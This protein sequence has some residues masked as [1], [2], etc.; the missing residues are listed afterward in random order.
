[1]IDNYSGLNALNWRLGS[2][3]RMGEKKEKDGENVCMFEG[4]RVG[5]GAVGVDGRG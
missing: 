1:M 2:G 5:W 3:G 4:G